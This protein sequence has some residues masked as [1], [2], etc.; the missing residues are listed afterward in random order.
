M[1][2]SEAPPVR[3]RPA[4]AADAERLA[5]L[6]AEGEVGRYIFADSPAEHVERLSRPDERVLVGEDTD[7]GFLGYVIFRG[8]ENP[9]RSRE[10][11][12]LAVAR[13]GAGVGRRLLDAAVRYGF[14]ELDAHRVWLDVFTDNARAWALYR[15]YGFVE[16]GRHRECVHHPELGWRSLVVLSLLE[17]EAATAPA[18]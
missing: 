7:G 2:P 5:A 14:A 10:L 9:H 16:E 12:R 13:R 1:P 6:D 15:A 4:S 18:S 11:M 3:L 8:V 17:H